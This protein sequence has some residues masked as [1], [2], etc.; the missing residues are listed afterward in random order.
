MVAPVF[1]QVCFKPLMYFKKHA[2]VC[3]PSLVS[4]YKQR[5]P[6]RWGH[7]FVLYHV[8]LEAQCI[9][10]LFHH[11]T[12]NSIHK[13]ITIRRNTASILDCGSVCFQSDHSCIFLCKA[14]GVICEKTIIVTHMV[15]F[16]LTPTTI[17]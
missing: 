6:L 2:R 15:A 11:H 3:F 14:H 13:I 4:G 1:Q 10:V 5:E 16:F 9:C 12:D 17:S 8:F 7:N